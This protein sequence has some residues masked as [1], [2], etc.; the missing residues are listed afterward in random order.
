[1]I[2][3]LIVQGESGG[4]EPPTKCL[5]YAKEITSRAALA[6]S[7]PPRGPQEQKEIAS[8]F[9]GVT[10]WEKICRE[11]AIPSEVLLETTD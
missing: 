7:L 8:C 5:N 3:F 1:M 9:V 2:G 4:E 10:T 6:S 11:F